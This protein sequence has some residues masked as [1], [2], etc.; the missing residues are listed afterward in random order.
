MVARKMR[1][2]HGARRL[3]RAVSAGW[4]L[5]G[6]SFAGLGAAYLVA[7]RRLV[8]QPPGC[9]PILT[10]SCYMRGHIVNGTSSAAIAAAAGTALLLARCQ[11]VSTSA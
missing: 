10:R 9:A 3:N 8:W 7:A 11:I 6:L 5:A 4:L 2:A 1:S